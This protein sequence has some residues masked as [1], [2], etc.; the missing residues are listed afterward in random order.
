[1]LFDLQSSLEDREPAVLLLALRRIA[2]A[3]GGMAKLAQATGLTCG[4][5]YG[6]LSASGN[7]RENINTSAAR[8]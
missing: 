7:P 3:C 8:Q 5:L 6:T 2:E 1:V 4:A